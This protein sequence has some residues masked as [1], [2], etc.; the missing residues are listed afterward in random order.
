MLLSEFWWFFCLVLMLCLKMSLCPWTHFPLL[1]LFAA[2]SHPLSGTHRSKSLKAGENRGIM[3]SA[4]AKLLPLNLLPFCLP[5]ANPDWSKD[6]VLRSRYWHNP[7]YHCSEC[8]LCVV[9]AYYDQAP[10]VWNLIWN[11]CIR[12]AN[13]I[14]EFISFILHQT[15]PGWD[16]LSTFLVPQSS[17]EA[18]LN[19]SCIRDQCSY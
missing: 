4:V 18:V 17:R 1:P 16:Q 9:N 14:L 19:L 7:F 11:L 8:L 10:Y 5:P 2:A 6:A 3:T 13:E 15:W 12:E